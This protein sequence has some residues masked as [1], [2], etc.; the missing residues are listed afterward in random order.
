MLDIISGLSHRYYIKYL[1]YID[2]YL[3]RFWKLSVK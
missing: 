2:T 1:I 3:M